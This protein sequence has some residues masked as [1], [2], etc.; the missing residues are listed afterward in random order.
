MHV[1]LSKLI[2]FA[3]GDGAGEALYACG[4]VIIALS[5]L[6]PRQVWCVPAGPNL[7][8]QC[9]LSCCEVFVQLLLSRCIVY[10]AIVLY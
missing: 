2:F 1:P 10:F 5:K 7:D 4:V 8:I 6:R 3:G 9:L